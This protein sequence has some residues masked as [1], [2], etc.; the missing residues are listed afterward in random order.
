MQAKRIHQGIVC[1]AALAG[2]LALGG[3]NIV[4]FGLSSLPQKAEARYKPP[5]TPMLVLVENQRNPGIAMVEADQLTAFIMD[6]L[7]AYKVAPLIELKKLCE[8]RDREKNID[9]MTITQIGSAAGAHQVLYVDLQRFNIGGVE[10]GI[11]M[12]ARVDVTVRLVDVKTSA[13]TFPAMGQGNWPISLET[14]ITA[15]LSRTNPDAVRESLL[16]SAGT[17]IGR[18]FHD[19]Q[20]N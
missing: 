4:A 10:E 9:K 2:L 11:P 8:L 7:A 20:V 6:D 12:Q 17:A 19:Y 5:A 14:P 15:N 3:C 1:L 18:L 13:T 16:R